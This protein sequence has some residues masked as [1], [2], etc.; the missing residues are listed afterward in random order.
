MS[1]ESELLEYLGRRELARLWPEV[2]ARIESLGGPRGTVLLAEAR[3]DERRAVAG[4]LGLATLP[5]GDVR[6]RLDRLDRALRESRFEVDLRT[7]MTLLGGPLRDRT[8]ERETERLRWQEL[9][10]DAETHPVVT[11]RPG[12]RSWLAG[13]RSSGLLRRLVAD[14]EE[15]RLLEQALAVL[16]A[17]ASPERDGVR[18]PVLASEILGTSHAL[19]AGRPVA[20]LVLR[21]LALLA[22]QPPPRNAGERRT[23]W[24]QAG[25]VTDDLSCD[26][27]VLGLVPA[28]EG[29][30]A[31][32]LRSFATAGEPVR[33]TLR[34]IAAG[35]LTFPPGLK[36]RVCENPV[37]VAAAA[38][39]WGPACPPLVCLGGFPNHA[40]RR[41]LADLASQGAG[42]LYHGDFDWAGLTIANSLG[43]TVPF[44]PWRFTA[45]DYQ[46]ALAQRCDRPALGDRSVPARW[47]L[48]LDHAMAEAGVAVEEETVLGDLIDDLRPSPSLRPP[49]P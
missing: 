20:T 9:W 24:E 45:R 31:Q 21:A 8:G 35:T 44:Q 18:L 25:V 3:D 37:V 42:L 49:T 14:G 7:A 4:L 22:G 41:L 1:P 17:L 46:A 13:L 10:A 33:L 32:G 6:I 29:P 19:D 28:G 16:T 38:D 30:I 48:E 47:D 26:V 27:L 5:S 43:E 15:R 36:V 11:V 34:Q 2:R 39:R 23:L 12:L 40:G